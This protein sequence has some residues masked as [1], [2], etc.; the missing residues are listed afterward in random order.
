MGGFYKIQWFMAIRWKEWVMIGVG[1]AI[2]TRMSVSVWKLWK[3]GERV[4]EAQAEVV[5]LEG[6]KAEFEKRLV[7]VKSPE[8]VERE[9]REKLGLGE[10]GERIIIVPK[11]ELEKRVEEPE[12]EPNWRKW[13]KLYGI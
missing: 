7:E 11:Q 3:A 10:P 6:E 8:F 12:M 4:E 13:W 5:R 2:A 1:V 9:A